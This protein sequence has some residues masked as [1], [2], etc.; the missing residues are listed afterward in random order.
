MHTSLIRY[1]INHVHIKVS[2]I[3]QYIYM[4]TFWSFSFACLVKKII[5]SSFFDLE[6][7]ILLFARQAQDERVPLFLRLTHQERSVVA[8]VVVQHFDRLKVTFYRYPDFLYNNVYSNDLFKTS[9][10]KFHFLRSYFEYRG[11]LP[12]FTKWTS[13][14]NKGTQH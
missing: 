14:Y 13:F 3:P 7:V 4:V 9:L 1:G 2:K 8:T 11:L 10:C 5:D 6:V 12:L